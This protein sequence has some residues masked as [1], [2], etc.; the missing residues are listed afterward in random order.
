MNRFITISTWAKLAGIN[1]ESVYKRIKKGSVKITDLCEHP[2]IDIEEYPPCKLKHK[3]QPLPIKRDLPN[4][5]KDLSPS[6]KT[7]IPLGYG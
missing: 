7:H 3:H 4:W 1:R 6:R 2:L 5:C